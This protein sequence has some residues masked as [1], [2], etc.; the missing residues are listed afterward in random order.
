MMV[1]KCQCE[2]ARDKA[3]VVF[4]CGYGRLEVH[5]GFRIPDHLRVTIK[6]I[7]MRMTMPKLTGVANNSSVLNKMKILQLVRHPCLINLEGVIDNANFLYIVLQFAQGGE[8]FDKIINKTK[9]NEDETVL[10]LYQIISAI[11]YLQ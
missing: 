5:L 8:V 10:Y 11:Q 7:S 9:L 2:I 6:I 4:L 3:G 1:S